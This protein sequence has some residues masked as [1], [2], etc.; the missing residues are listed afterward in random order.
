M[1]KEKENTAGQIPAIYGQM[2]E[3]MEQ[4]KAITKDRKN[5]Q[6]NFMFRGIDDIINELH[7]T[8]A[9]NKVFILPYVEEF[10]VAEKMTKQ[11]GTM[12]YTRATVT[13]EF[14]SGIDGSRVKVRNVGEAMDSGDKSMNKAMSVSL[15]YALLQILLIA[16]KETKDPDETT[17]ESTMPT[18]IVEAMRELDAVTSR[19]QFNAVYRKYNQIDPTILQAGTPLYDKLREVGQKYPKSK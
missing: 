2:A 18:I 7:D 13:Y 19:E 15:K 10:S 11:G 14:V 6:Q 4:T 8:F 3:I 1:E 16:T 9:A 12:Y 17:P 5:Q